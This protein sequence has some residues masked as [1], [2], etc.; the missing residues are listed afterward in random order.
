MYSQDKIDVALNVY[1]QCGNGYNLSLLLAREKYFRGGNPALV[2]DEN[3]KPN[4]LIEG[5]PHPPLCSSI[6]G[7]K[8]EY[9]DGDRHLKGGHQYL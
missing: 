1:H 3:I 7:L 4:T 2:N 8:Q 9:A 5:L 6:T